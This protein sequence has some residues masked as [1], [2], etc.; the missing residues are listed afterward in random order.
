MSDIQENTVGTQDPTPLEL[1][2]HQVPHFS[3]INNCKLGG[4]LAVQYMKKKASHPICAITRQPLQGVKTCRPK[5]YRR[6]KKRFRKVSRPYGG[7][8][9]AGEVRDR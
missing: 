2:A 7:T 9:S 3:L 5:E 4:K 6:I 1:F 8:L